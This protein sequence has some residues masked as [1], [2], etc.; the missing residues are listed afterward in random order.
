MIALALLVASP[1]ID[2]SDEQAMGMRLRLLAHATM[3][4]LAALLYRTV[5]VAIPKAARVGATA[6]ALVFALALV[7]LAPTRSEEGVIRTHPALDQ[8]M[9]ATDGVMPPGG[10]FIT[11]ERHVLYMATWYSRRPGSSRPIGA[12]RSNTHSRNSSRDRSSRRLISENTLST[13]QPPWIRE[14]AGPSRA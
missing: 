11:Q 7:S 4:P 6:S 9:R 5:I 1:L 2:T 3:G 13:T 12:C 8:A 10:H 14:P